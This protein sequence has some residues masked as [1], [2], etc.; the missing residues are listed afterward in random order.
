MNDNR[1]QAPRIS[2]GPEHTVQF[3]AGGHAFQGI[4]ISNLSE[5]GCFLAVPRSSAGV[6]RNGTLLE[7]FRLEGPGLPP[8]SLTGVVAF[9]MGASPGLPVVGLGVRFVAL[10]ESIQ[11]ELRRFVDEALGRIRG[12]TP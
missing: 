10:P 2:L 7:Q 9:A 8:D 11:G 3:T 4:R 6:F 12:E 1:R 5:G